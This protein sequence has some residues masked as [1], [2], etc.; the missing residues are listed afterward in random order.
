MQA[1]IEKIKSR[2]S[3]YFIAN[4]LTKIGGNEGILTKGNVFAVN[5]EGNHY[6]VTKASNGIVVTHL[7]DLTELLKLE[8]EHLV[9]FI[10]ED[11]LVWHEAEFKHFYEDSFLMDMDMLYHQMYPKGKKLSEH[12]FIQRGKGN[13]RIAFVPLVA[14]DSWILAEILESI[15]DGDS[16]NHW[17]VHVDLADYEFYHKEVLK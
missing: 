5:Y 16:S 15:W 2:D 3:A 9:S 12:C 14:D 6:R 1:F 8:A 4:E 13:M 17:K 11:E 7:K 10:Q